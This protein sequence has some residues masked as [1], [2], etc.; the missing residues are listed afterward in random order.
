MSTAAIPDLTP[1]PILDA[2]ERF[3]GSFR[4]L[5]RGIELDGSGLRASR[6]ALVKRLKAL[7]IEPG[8]RILLSAGNGPGFVAALVSVLA[9][10]GSPVLLHVDTPP[11][12]LKR[13]SAAYGASFA[14]AEAWT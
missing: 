12:E 4:D 5:D 13:L 10:G 6:D 7:G 2:F 1:A 14:L 9:V 8:D 3:A 11:A